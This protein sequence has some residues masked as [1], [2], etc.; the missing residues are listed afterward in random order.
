MPSLATT[1]KVESL[2]TLQGSKDHCFSPLF[3]KALKSEYLCVG[4][5]IHRGI[6]MSG[7][8]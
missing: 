3:C 8:M 2:Q 4:V 7:E 5:Y 1:R 6:Y